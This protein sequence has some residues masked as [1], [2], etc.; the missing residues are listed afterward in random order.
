MKIERER[1]IEVLK[2]LSRWPGVVIT[3]EEKEAMKM[4]IE[5]L[6]AQAR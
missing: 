6:E 3:D 5:A 2:E 1:A 4:G